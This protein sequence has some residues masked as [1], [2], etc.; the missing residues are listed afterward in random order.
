MIVKKEKSENIVFDYHLKEFPLVVSK[1]AKDF[2][3]KQEINYGL[4]Q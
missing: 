2:L 4:W 3:N 1:P